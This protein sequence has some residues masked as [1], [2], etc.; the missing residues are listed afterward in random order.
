MQLL[1]ARNKTPQIEDPLFHKCELCVA[2][3]GLCE[4]GKLDQFINGDLTVFRSI[5]SSESFSPP[6]VSRTQSFLVLEKEKKNNYTLL[7]AREG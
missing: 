1:P 3:F 5:I 7:E 4:N 2:A 6:I